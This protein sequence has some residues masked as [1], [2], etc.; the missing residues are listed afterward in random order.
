MN[1][2][3]PE[4]ALRRKLERSRSLRA[5]LI[6]T[7]AILIVFVTLANKPQIMSMLEG[8]EEVTAEFATRYKVDAYD[9]T[10][11]MAGIEVGT[12]TAVET[13]DN[14]RIKVTMKVDED[15]VDQFGSEPTASIEPRT[16]LGGRY[17]I[18]IH[19]AGGSNFSGHIPVERTTT[20]VELDR[21]LEALPSD[22]RKAVQG[23]T[24]EVSEALPASEDSIA[25]LLDTSAELLEPGT[26]VVRAAEGTAPEQDLRNIVTRFDTVAKALTAE[27]GQLLDIAVDLNATVGTLAA[28]RRPLAQTVNTL[29]TTLTNLRRG[30]TGLESTL[31]ELK[32]AA[33]SLKPSVPEVND[34]I[35]NLDPLLSEAQPLLRE[36]RPV[37]RDANPAV[38]ELVP[39]VRSGN[40]VLKDLDGP[41]LNRLRGPVTTFLLNPW[42]GKGPYAGATDGYM[43]DHKVY[44]E[45]AYMATNID[46]ASSFQDHYGSTFGF[47]IGVNGDTVNIG[48]AVSLEN[49]IELALK[50]VGM[51]NPTNSKAAL[52]EVAGR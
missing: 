33:V 39:A 3:N 10:V 24:G 28:Q 27:Q 21:V 32:T 52:K 30:T 51:W 29:P 50:Q 31:A 19:P 35:A 45:L 12:V 47:Q 8:G 5:G 26:K 44:E 49:I 17:A 48:P 6:T 4:R 1:R 20:P 34:L 37:L 42:V 36:L 7:A 40:G 43:A 25:H 18:E 11:K 13:L 15:A 23:L 2:E 14:G 41:V 9:S 16:L 38:K 46:R 22:A